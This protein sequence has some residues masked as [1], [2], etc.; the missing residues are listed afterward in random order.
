MRPAPLIVWGTGPNS[1]KT[2]ISVGL[3]RH[4]VRH[5]RQVTPF[6]AVTVVESEQAGECPIPLH[7]AAA[8]TRWRPELSPVTLRRDSLTLAMGTT[9]AGPV[10]LATPD[11]LDLAQLPPEVATRL[12][13]TVRAALSRLSSLDST[14]L[15]EGAGSPLDAVRDLA[16][17]EVVR[18]L[19]EGASARPRILL[20]HYSGAG[21]SQAALCGTY[22]LL[23]RDVRRYVIGY[24]LSGPLPGADVASW[25]RTVTT[26]TGLPLIG[27]IPRLTVHDDADQRTPDV[28]ADLWAD[29]VGRH[30]SLEVLGL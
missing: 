5:G 22:T 3:A 14:L 9:K 11:T 7:V 16:N 17:L 4:L 25:S 6:K 24:L 27:V 18:I 12:V 30:L 1:S 10:P 20:S 26:Y 2:H 19:A 8:R 13:A 28:L 29:A 21:G 23:P 15:V